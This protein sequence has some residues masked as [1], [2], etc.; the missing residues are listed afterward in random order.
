MV[1]AIKV[2]WKKKYCSL[3]KWCYTCVKGYD[4]LPLCKRIDNKDRKQ[5]KILITIE[6]ESKLNNC[7]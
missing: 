2:H 5:K 4:F 1:Y 7:P 6:G 3:P